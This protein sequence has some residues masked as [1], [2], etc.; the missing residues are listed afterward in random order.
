MLVPGLMARF[1]AARIEDDVR[2]CT[3]GA[4]E[5]DPHVEVFQRFSAD[6]GAAAGWSCSRQKLSDGLTGRLKANDHWTDYASVTTTENFVLWCGAGRGCLD[7]DNAAS[8]RACGFCNF[9]WMLGAQIRAW[10][11]ASHH[12]RGPPGRCRLQLHRRLHGSSPSWRSGPSPG[13]DVQVK[14]GAPEMFPLLTVPLPF[15][16]ASATKTAGRRCVTNGLLRSK[17]PFTATSCRRWEAAPWPYLPVDLL[18]IF[19]AWASR[20]KAA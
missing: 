8:R 10:H 14:N 16:V 4:R 3:L 13:G 19:V 2:G 1:G 11:V 5:I 6:V 18:P 17:E 20:P 7:A 12:R 15:G 9:M